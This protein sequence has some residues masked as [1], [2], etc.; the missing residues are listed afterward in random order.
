MSRNVCY[1][2]RSH[3]LSLHAL[4]LWNTIIL[5]FQIQY[6]YQVAVYILEWATPSLTVWLAYNEQMMWDDVVD[7]D[8]DECSD[9]D[10]DYEYLFLC[11]WWKRENKRL[12]EMNLR[13]EQENDD[14]AHELVN[15]KISL[16]NDLDSVS[17]V[18]CY[19]L[20]PS[21]HL[22]FYVSEIL[23]LEGCCKIKI[24][25][26]FFTHL[27]CAFSALRW[28]SDRK[29]IKL[30]KILPQQCS[31][32]PWQHDGIRGVRNPMKISDIGFLKTEPTSKFKNRKVGFCGSVF[33][34]PTL[35]VRERFFTLSHSQFI[36]QHDRIRSLKYFSSAVSLHF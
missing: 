3:I 29:G 2:V 30:L 21:W 14:L 32:S 9:D 25:S 28:L 27:S 24:F 26:M 35:A 7:I 20:S 33:K 12:T 1:T 11:W 23:I 17:I 15:S 10:A 31:C 19:A 13:L 8:D 6:K 34:K 16:R 18:L 4:T 5:S 22:T 36:L